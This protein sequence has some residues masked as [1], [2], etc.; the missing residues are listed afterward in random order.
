MRQRLADHEIELWNVGILDL[1]CDPTM[2]LGLPGFDEKLDRYVRYLR[3][4]GR[5]GIGYTTCAHMANIK[6][7]PY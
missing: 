7:R 5:A 3:D 4:L 6:M 1:H 2:V